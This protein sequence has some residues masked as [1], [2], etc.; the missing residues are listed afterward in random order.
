MKVEVL[1]GGTFWLSESP[2][3]PGSM[4]W[5]STVPCIATWAISFLSIILSSDT[6]YDF[7]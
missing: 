4:S 2:S 5:G 6:I 7:F 1:E 3:V